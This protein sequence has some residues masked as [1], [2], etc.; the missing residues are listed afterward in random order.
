MYA[1]EERDILV[2]LTLE[3]WPAADTD[4]P[5]VTFNVRYANVLTS[6][7]ETTS[8]SV[9]VG[10]PSVSHQAGASLKVDDIIMEFE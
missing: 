8:T 10:R 2:Q 6:S 5:L 4:Q 3:A 7:L 1:E 9:T